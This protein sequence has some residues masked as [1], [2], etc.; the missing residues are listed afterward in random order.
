MRK[1]LLF[2]ILAFISLVGIGLGITQLVWVNNQHPPKASIVDT[3]EKQ[4]E[5]KI[6]DGIE[7][8]ES[9]QDKEG[10]KYS[11]YVFHEAVDRVTK[12]VHHPGEPA[13]THEVYH[14][15]VYGTRQARDCIRVTITNKNGQCA[16]SQC[17]DGEY[18]GSTGRGTCSYHGGVA[19]RG[20]PWYVYHE[21]SYLISEGWTETVIDKP[22]VSAWDETVEV[23]PAK[24]AYYEKVLAE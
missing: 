14:E 23:A 8:K 5:I 17:R 6:C 4:E 3:N 12:I 18:S 16:L 20:G 9:C 10:V 21:E 7:V 15:P 11:K 2:S 24:E 1:K 13:A 22:A 19:R